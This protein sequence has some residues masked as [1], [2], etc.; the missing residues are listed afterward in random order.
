MRARYLLLCLGLL[1]LGETA[2][3]SRVAA[4]GAI[5][6]VRRIAEPAFQMAWSPDG[7]KIAVASNTTRHSYSLWDVA[8]G[9]LLHE[10]STSQGALG[11]K[12]A[13]A[14]APDGKHVIV[15]SPQLAV[16]GDVALALWNV[17]TGLIDGAILTPPSLRSS[18]IQSYAVSPSTEQLAVLF[19]DNLI[20]IY[21][22]RSWQLQATWIPQAPVAHYPSAFAFD[23]SGQLI[24][25]GGARRGS[26]TGDPRGLVVAYEAIT[27]RLV[28]IIEQAHQDGVQNVVFLGTTGLIATTA[29]RLSSMTNVATGKVEKPLDDDPV[30][31]WLLREGLRTSS[32]EVNYD[33]ARAM[34]A[35]AD[36]KRFALAATGTPST[37]HIWTAYG[38][39]WD[40]KWVSDD[41]TYFNAL[42]FSPDGHRI[43]ASRVRNRAASFEVV[44]LAV[45]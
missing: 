11:P 41:S 31:V 8:S 19:P 43:A 29:N 35:S 3:D 4:D 23:P 1:A 22:T 13:V 6:I 32:F 30:R 24:V 10:L 5:A 44:I 36:G 14:F 15:Q 42:A 21:D 28:R 12:R 26:Y 37:L 20:A 2:A 33:G 7:S 9:K 25:W 38:E 16:R 45:P 39:L 17:E 18:F 40:H 34:S 27:G